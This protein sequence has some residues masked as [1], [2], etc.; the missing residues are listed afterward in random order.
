MVWKETC[1]VEERLRFVMAVEAGEES[2]AAICRRFGVSRRVGYKWYERYVRDGVPGLS[3]RS[4]AP[5]RRPRSLCAELAAACLA[6]RRSHPS[7][8]P[9]KVRAW[10][11]RRDPDVA[12]PA[13]STIGA[14]FD[15]EGLTVKRRVRRRVPPRS[16]PFAACAAAND[17]WCIDFKGWFRTGDGARCEPLT[18]SDAHSRY[19]LRCQ[20][21]ARADTAH[22]WPILDAALRE[23]GLPVALRSD[24][25]P[26]FA[27]T[28]AGGL[29]RLSVLAIKAG[30]RP[31][32][33]APAKPQQNGRHERLHLTLK[34]ETASPPAAD[35]RRQI[36]RFRAFQRLYNFE[37]PHAALDHDTP[38]DRYGPAVRV[39]DGVLREPPCP[40]DAERRR[41]RRSGEI[42]WKGN[43]IYIN[44]A[45]AGEAVALIEQDDGLWQVRYGPIELGGIDHRGQRLQRPKRKARG[46]V[47]NPD[48]LPTSPPAQQPKHP[49]NAT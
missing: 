2:L 40:D 19:L 39:W 23:Y 20:A 28:G 32:R 9:V 43:A 33:I 5:H 25:G 30:V 15:R 29:S 6:V 1:A 31:E 38:A 7:W 4:R 48:G 34:Q 47:D 46:L 8:G 13:A 27:S 36:E 21:V 41:V 42:K 44:Q 49:L 3:D 18:L 26:P 45:L 17:V 16:A 35:L 10:L 11:Q 37:R 22:V 14:L 12:W 24:N